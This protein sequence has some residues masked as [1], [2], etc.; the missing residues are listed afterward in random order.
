MAKGLERCLYT[1]IAENLADPECVFWQHCDDFLQRDNL[2][3][4]FD[5][6]VLPARKMTLIGRT[7][8]AH[9]F[10]RKKVNFDHARME[11]RYLREIH[12]ERPNCFQRCVDDHFLLRSERWLQTL[13]PNQRGF[14]RAASPPTSHRIL[15]AVCKRVRRSVPW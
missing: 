13:P 9:D 6:R 5:A 11:L 15:P 4:L 8:F 2:D 10:A 12:A 1:V 7:C 3:V 14:T